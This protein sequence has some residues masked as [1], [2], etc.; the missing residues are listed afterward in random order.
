MYFTCCIYSIVVYVFL[1]CNCV[2]ISVQVPNG[3]CNILCERGWRFGHSVVNCFHLQVELL[4]FVKNVFLLGGEMRNLFICVVDAQSSS[5]SSGLIPR[6]MRS[7]ISASF[8]VLMSASVRSPSVH[9]SH[10]SGTPYSMSSGSID[11][12]NGSA[13]SGS[14]LHSLHFL[15]LFGPSFI[16]MVSKVIQSRLMCL[17]WSELWDLEVLTVAKDPACRS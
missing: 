3:E 4:K 1:T 12:V 14:R 7:E 13:L 9:F 16:S 5:T 17:V 11:P 10:S 15:A 2:S 8:V 6:S